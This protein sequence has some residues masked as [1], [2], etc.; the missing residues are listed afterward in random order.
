MRIRL[1]SRHLR[2]VSSVSG[3]I[4]QFQLFSNPPAPNYDMKSQKNSSKKI[5]KGDERLQ[6]A[7]VG[8]WAP[9][10]FVG[11]AVGFMAQPSTMSA[12]EKM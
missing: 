5:T 12:G 10:H 7:Y 6:P 11:R 9:I 4:P 1:G 8:S 2:I 3:L